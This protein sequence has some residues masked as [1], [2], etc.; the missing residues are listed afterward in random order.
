MRR[1]WDELREHGV[2]PRYRLGNV[3]E[4]RYVD[5]VQEDR[6][7]EFGQAKLTELTS[8]CR[9][10]PVRWACHGGCPKDRFATSRD[11]ERGHNYLCEGCCSFFGHAGPRIHRLAR[12]IAMG[13]PVSSEGP[14]A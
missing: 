3:R 4:D 9:S 11:G 13:A 7:V 6:Q 14:T 5:L 8:Q 10:C 12:E 1:G 2:E